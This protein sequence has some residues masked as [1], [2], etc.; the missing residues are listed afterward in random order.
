MDR[1]GRICDFQPKLQFILETT[2]RNVLSYCGSL[3]EV[4]GSQL[5]R[6]GSNDHFQHNTRGGGACFKGLAMSQSKGRDPSVH[7]FF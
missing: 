1:V 6:V 4:T 2:K 7:K 5:I 3:T